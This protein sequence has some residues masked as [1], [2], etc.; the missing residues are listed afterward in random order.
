MIYLHLM[1]MENESVN[2]ANV[3]DDASGSGHGC[4]IESVSDSEVVDTWSRPESRSKPHRERWKQFADP[5][6]I[7]LITM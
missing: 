2:V 7:T 4:F 1:T 3:F 5:C 6:F